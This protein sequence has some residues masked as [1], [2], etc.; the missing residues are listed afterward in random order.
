MNLLTD[1]IK[2]MMPKLG[3]TEKTPCDE[4]EFIVKFFNPMGRGTWLVAEGEKQED[5][6]WLF[7]GLVDLFEK[8][9]GYFSL[10]ELEAV[11]VGF[12]LGIER[13][14]CYGPEWAHPEW[15]AM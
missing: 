12:G 11:D 9:W 3:S 6:D 14:I 7:F 5:G 15:A 8:E 2:Y 13:D 4:K 10:S 1:K